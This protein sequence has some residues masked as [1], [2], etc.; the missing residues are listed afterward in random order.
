MAAKKAGY[1]LTELARGYYVFKANGIEVEIASKLG[2]KPLAVLD[3]MGESDYAFLNDTDA[4]AKAGATLKLT[5]IDPAAYAAVY[6]VG[7]KGAMFD[8]PA[9]PHVARIVAAIA[10]RSG[11]AAQGQAGRWQLPHGRAPHDGCQQ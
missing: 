4:Q 1:E 11:G 7:G 5:E 3:D 8:L 2:G 10:P 9:D 6:V